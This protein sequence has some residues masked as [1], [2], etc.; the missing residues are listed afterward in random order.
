MNTSEILK[1]NNNPEIKRPAMEDRLD[2]IHAGPFKSKSAFEFSIKKYASV[3]HV[4]LFSK[5]EI[6]VAVLENVQSSALNSRCF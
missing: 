6:H 4:K 3:M 5:S 1:L 2:T